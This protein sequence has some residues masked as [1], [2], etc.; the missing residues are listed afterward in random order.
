VAAGTLALAALALPSGA[1]PPN[2]D[3]VPPDGTPPRFVTFDAAADSVPAAVD[4]AFG[5][6]PLAF[7][8]NVGQT[9]G[10][11]DFLARRPGYTLFLTPAEA[12][13]AFATPGDG[14]VLRLRLDGARADAPAAGEA[15]L[16]GKVN[17]FIGSDP[18]AWRTDVPTWGRVR[19]TEIYRGVDLVWY[20]NGRELEFDLV[21]A[22][23]ADPSAIR[24]AFDGV[25]RARLAQTGDLVLE[26]GGREVRQTR[27]VIW[28]QTA[29]GRRE[30]EGGYVL[31]GGA[32]V[33]FDVGAYD[34]TLPLV[35][36]PVLVYG[37]FLGGTG[38]DKIEDVAVNAAGNLFATGET[39]SPNFPTDGGVVINAPK[40]G[41]DVFV[42][43]LNPGGTDTEY[44]TYVGGSSV[45]R[46]FGIA[47]DPN[48]NRAWVTG[49]TQSTNFPVVNAFQS[50]LSVSPPPQNRDGF[51][52]KLNANGN[53]LLLSSYFG[54]PEE[55][56]GVAIAVN[57]SGDAYM[58]GD[59]D[60]DRA[61]LGFVPPAGGLQ[62][63]LGG[64]RD[65][66][67]LKINGNNT[68][69][70]FT[71]L[72]GSFFDEVLNVAVDGD[73]NAYLTG[74]TESSDFLTLNGDASFATFD[75]VGSGPS[76]GFVVKLGPAG[77]DLVYGSFLGGSQDEDGHGIALDADRNAYVTGFTAS[78]DFP[79]AGT[80]FQAALNGDP[81]LTMDAYVTKVNA[82]G[83]A[84]VYSTYLGGAANEVGFEVAVDP[85]G[86]AFVVGTTGSVDFPTANSFDSHGGGDDAFVTGVGLTGS[87]LTFSTFLGGPNNEEGNGI[88]VSGCAGSVYA[89]GA[90]G[91]LFDETVA[92]SFDVSYNG[93]TSDAFAVRIDV[94]G[95]A[96]A[97]GIPDQLE[98]D[99]LPPTDPETKDNDVFAADPAGN[100]LFAMQQFRDFVDREGLEGGITFWANA[101]TNAAATRAEVVR[102][103]H[104][105]AEYQNN[106]A[107]VIRLAL[108]HRQG[109][110]SQIPVFATLQTLF[111]QFPET[112]DLFDLSATLAA[113]PEWIARYGTGAFPDDP[114]GNDAFVTQVFQDLLARAPAQAGLDYWSNQLD[115]DVI[116]RPDLFAFI[117]ETNEFKARIANEQFVVSIFTEMLRRA[118]AQGGFTFWVNQLDGGGSNLVLIDTVLA[119]TEYRNRFLP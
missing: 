61:S 5:R 107:N 116:T 18:A 89:G 95:D 23:G 104:D 6:M 3:A 63:D 91:N 105:S 60:N 58:V 41:R 73:G 97:D 77:N 52:L 34:R 26:V 72:G 47:L 20:G 70:Y 35:I 11:V 81:I 90:A 16:A 76:D 79:T 67:V 7:E 27:P 68:L 17:Y 55:D 37:T 103:F 69:N 33:R 96:D 114:A 98:A 85:C 32:A 83:D 45:D 53:A 74:V 49:S 118:P 100:R 31:D 57:A 101:L 62:P 19:Y 59:L 38:L 30:V 12:V 108:A 13:F 15:E 10:A 51:V 29:A 71:Y 75:A 86:R 28:Q 54:G 117:S 84:L 50:S 109:F 43:K 87:G 21:V 99:N 80:P 111:G 42:T 25:A 1:L 46:A 40:G 106:F 2:L 102:F 36:D 64:G 110:A 14:T 92:G 115:A 78:D 82:A 8:P 24:L 66:F 4:D 88:A 119:S 22:P 9:H 94:S 39:G 113:D 48:N 44:S 65:G 93:G 56:S 112:A